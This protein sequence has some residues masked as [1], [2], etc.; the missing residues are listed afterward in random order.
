MP[1]RTI[2]NRTT[3]HR[4][5]PQRTVLVTGASRGIGLAIA[6]QYCNCGYQVLA[7]S[8]AELDLGSRE[9][10][11]E[12]FADE[13]NLAVDVLVNNAAE[14]PIAPLESL[15]LDTFEHCLGVNLSA[16]LKLIQA[17]APHM[18]T[19]GWG[20]I[21]NLSSC[22]AKVSRQGRASYGAAKAGL[23]SLTRTACLEFAGSRVAGEFGLSRLRCHRTHL[24][25]QFRPANRGDLRRYS[26][27]A[28]GF[29][30]RDRLVRLLPRQRNQYP[31]SPAR[32]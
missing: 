27:R 32:P 10:I 6:T 22:Y 7:P 21:V 9:S 1:N 20:R 26:P 4:T 23:N 24:P 28:L 12:F 25:Q 5:V 19:Q 14:N 11:D 2:P 16:P 31:T 15:P 17:V 13:R 29:P 30:R 3:P 8:R 18:R